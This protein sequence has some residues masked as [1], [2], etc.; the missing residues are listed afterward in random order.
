[1]NL[2]LLFFASIYYKLNLITLANF[3]RKDIKRG[4]NQN[5]LELKSVFFVVWF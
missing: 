4:G 2:N 5:R 3:Q 1:M